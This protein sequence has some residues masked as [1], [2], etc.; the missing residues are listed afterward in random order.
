[1]KKESFDSPDPL[2]FYDERIKEL[3][4]LKSQTQSQTLK[5]LISSAIDQSNDSV[6]KVIA[7]QKATIAYVKK[8]QA[9]YEESRIKIDEQLDLLRKE[10]K[11]VEA[12]TDI[13][14]QQKSEAFDY[15][16]GVLDVGIKTRNNKEEVLKL[17]GVIMPK[18][19]LEFQNL[20]LNLIFKPNATTFHY[21]T[22]VDALKFLAGLFIPGFDS[23]N[24]ARENPLSVILRKKQYVRTGDK[25]LTYIEQYLDVLNKW[26]SLADQYLK[27]LED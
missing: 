12:T 11:K 21:D 27:I 20:L 5:T 26:G 9:E 22:I 14:E 18:A 19:A 13:S 24:A 4:T 15:L 16:K 2:K 23:I 17:A 8:E 6:Q 7:I 1:M 10:I 25:I 3:E